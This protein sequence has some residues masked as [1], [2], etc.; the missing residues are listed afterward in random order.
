[1]LFR[2][3]TSADDVEVYKPEPDIFTA[4]LDKLGDV[5]PDEVLVVGDTPYDVE[6]AAKINLQTICVLCGGF[7]EEELYSTGCV[8]IFQDPSDILK[9]YDDSVIVNPPQPKSGK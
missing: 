7:P 5:A 8:A 9:H 4:A 6:A 3:E 1:M 2:S